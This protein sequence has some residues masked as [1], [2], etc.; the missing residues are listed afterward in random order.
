M[1]T[2]CKNEKGL[3]IS[4]LIPPHLTPSSFILTGTQSTEQGETGAAPHSRLAEMSGQLTCPGQGSR[5]QQGP[6]Q[7]SMETRVFISPP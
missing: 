1:L 2:G 5:V 4:R 7:W 3:E 6:S